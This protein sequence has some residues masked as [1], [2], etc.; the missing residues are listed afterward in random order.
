MGA[1]KLKTTICLIQLSRFSWMRRMCCSVSQ[2]MI[3][4]SVHRTLGVG[5]NKRLKVNRN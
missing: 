3:P 1:S 4:F 5:S 2:K